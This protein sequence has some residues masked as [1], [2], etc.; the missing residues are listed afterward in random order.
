MINNRLVKNRITNRIMRLNERNLIVSGQQQQKMAVKFNSVDAFRRVARSWRLFV[1]SANGITVDRWRA[2]IAPRWM[3][4][5]WILCR[6]V[7]QHRKS[8]RRGFV[9][10]GS[11]SS[12]ELKIVIK[13]KSV[14]GNCEKSN[15]C[16]HHQHRT[17]P[18][19]D[20]TE[21]WWT[22][23]LVWRP[24]YRWPCSP[25]CIRAPEYC[26]VWLRLAM[27]RRTLAVHVGRLH[28]TTDMVS[29][30]YRLRCSRTRFCLVFVAPSTA[31]VLEWWNKR[32]K[33]RC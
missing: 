11:S 12:W 16:T 24:P 13:I 28:T 17:L 33:N 18:T 23:C 22:D 32:N 5:V 31:A 27:N 6:H 9:R 4:S 1:P 26:A 29:V 14:A 3:Q 2:P 21:S 25:D 15:C 19:T 10:W 20:L 7:E 8:F 30:Q